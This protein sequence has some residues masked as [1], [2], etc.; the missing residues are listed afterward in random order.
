[1]LCGEED[2]EAPIETS[3]LSK[4]LQDELLCLQPL[5]VLRKVCRLFEVL[6]GGDGSIFASMPGTEACVDASEGAFNPKS[7]SG[8]PTSQIEAQMSAGVTFPILLAG[9][10]SPGASGTPAHRAAWAE[11]S[12][13]PDRFVRAVGIMVEEGIIASDLDALA[14]GV[15]IPL[16]E[17]IAYCRE[18]PS[19]SWSPSAC[20]FIG[21]EDIVLQ[22]T[23]RRLP[24]LHASQPPAISVPADKENASAQEVDGTEFDGL[25]T[26]LIFRTDAEMKRLHSVRDMLCSSNDV[27]VT[28]EQQM[29]MSD[30]DL[31]G[32]QQKELFA[33]V[34]RSMAVSV[35][36]GMLTLA[37]G[38]ILATEA[39]P[40]S[41]ISLSG[42]VKDAKTV[43]QVSKY[44]D[45]TALPEDFI[46]WPRFHSGVAAALRIARSISERAKS[47]IPSGGHAGTASTAIAEQYQPQIT[48]AWITYNKPKEPSC[49]HA[50]FLLGLGLHGHLNVLKLPEIL[51]YLKESHPPTSIGLL[52]G[53]A[54][55]KKGTMHNQF[56][57]L[58]SVHIPA[59]HP[60]AARD[61]E[62]AAD[63]Q[64]AALLG[65]GMLYQGSK[66]RRMT[67]V[68]LDEIGRPP[69]EDKYFD[70]ESYALISGISTG[71]VLLGCGKDTM[72]LKDIH[73]ED[74]LLRYVVGNDAQSPFQE[75][76]IGGE[77][78]ALDEPVKKSSVVLEAAGRVNTDVTAGGAVV[79][80]ALQYVQTNDASMAG[81]LAVPDTVFLL[82][83]VRPD[84]LMLRVT[85]R[86]IILWDAVEA[87]QDWLESQLPPVIYEHIAD[88]FSD[89]FTPLERETLEHA[90]L[91][92]TAGAALALGLR[93]AGTHSKKALAVVMQQAEVLLAAAEHKPSPTQRP[94]N[95]HLVE[96]CLLAVAMASAL[97]MAGSGDESSQALYSRLYAR[98]EA[99]HIT[100]GSHMAVG[101]CNGML[102]LGGGTMT[103]KRTPE[104]V[105]YLLCAVFPFYPSETRD[106]QFHLQPLRHLYVL[107]TESRLLET[108]D[109]KTRLPC[110]V[111]LA[112]TLKADKKGTKDFLPSPPQQED[113]RKAVTIHVDA[114][115]ILPELSL[116]ESIRVLGDKYWAS[117]MV[118]DDVSGERMLAQSGVMFVMRRTGHLEYQD[119][120]LGQRSE[121]VRSFPS[122]SLLLPSHSDP[123]RKNVKKRGKK[124][125]EKER[126]ALD[127]LANKFGFV[128]CCSDPVL[129]TFAQ[130]FCSA[131]D[132][133]LTEFCCSI[134]ADCLAR[135][136]ADA[137]PVYLALHL[138]VQ[139]LE[140]VAPH[141]IEAASLRLALRAYSDECCL[142]E[143]MEGRE[144]MLQRA[145]L[146]SVAM[147]VQRF[148]ENTVTG[149]DGHALLKEYARGEQKGGLRFARF[150]QLYP[151][152]T[153]ERIATAVKGSASL[154][155]LA[156][157]LPEC[158]EDSLLYLEPLM[159]GN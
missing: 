83:G 73:V 22:Y 79:A 50:G 31:L 6:H 63:V 25:M 130:H 33:L 131:G 91:H 42:R 37:S 116:I 14:L 117:T 49:Q 145:F 26:R 59:L 121:Y 128:K 77:S 119:D 55:S 106:D 76:T 23:C 16:K 57:K 109:V 20:S 108:R 60:P 46:K 72:E 137:L 30:H 58:F 144:T 112:V 32:L 129:L 100:Y 53:I 98:P 75:R 158:P 71:L 86:N 68:F 126:G 78:H 87:T 135:D 27:V 44:P 74:R 97:I 56:G 7:F 143:D 142:M 85:C 136:Q 64:A 159:E 140:E 38:S 134:L 1:M 96:R 151:I 36:R 67:E 41:E 157:A 34:Q 80:L 89:R 95:P 15:A 62:V 66:H 82:D 150:L 132:A 8:E 147:A 139:G 13:I 35:G 54:A 104:A 28:V 149:G 51:A 103:L 93:F 47:T 110:S 148:A 69:M 9:G 3:F 84:I 81:A 101:M 107:A 111:P 19:P 43:L 92:I 10:C 154:F 48:S 52:L 155:E 156:A 120:P 146:E 45:G 61:L 2:H 39:V 4:G 40:I 11:G 17:A 125:K 70:R 12:G 123:G 141:A 65:M 88:P 153:P 5:A 99:S 152:P 118:V 115:C 21:R 113:D 114:P 127:F 90:R 94:L 138:S 122:R 29:G 133:V 105:A 124:S 24:L 102:Y 18:H